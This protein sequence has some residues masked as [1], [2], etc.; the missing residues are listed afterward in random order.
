MNNLPTVTPVECL[1]ISPEALE[2]ANCFLQDQDLDK[3][4]DILD[5]PK[6]LVTQILAKRE[7]KAY[8]DNVFFN[9]G[10]N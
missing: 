2:V 9:L 4:A 1:D 6:E 10:Y 5:I 8:I 7:V 3:V